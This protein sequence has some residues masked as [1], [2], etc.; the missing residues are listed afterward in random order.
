MC[1]TRPSG[2]TASRRIWI[3]ARSPV[4]DMQAS[5]LPHTDDASRGAVNGGYGGGRRDGQNAEPRPSIGR[6]R[7]Q[8]RLSGGGHSQH[9]VALSKKTSKHPAHCAYL[10]PAQ[11]S[12]MLP[13]QAVCPNPEG[14]AAAAGQRCCNTGSASAHASQNPGHARPQSNEWNGLLVIWAPPLPCPCQ[15]VRVLLAEGCV[16]WGSWAATCRLSHTSG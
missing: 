16:L 2:P 14:A 1:I 13:K 11:A 12:C 9:Q 3:H 5:P 10:C 8:Q 7:P 15:Q 6:L 4:R